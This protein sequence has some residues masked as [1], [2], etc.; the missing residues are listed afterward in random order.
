VYVAV[1][2]AMSRSKEE[3]RNIGLIV[4]SSLKTKEQ[5]GGE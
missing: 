4:T 3:T 2:S 1:L 5:S